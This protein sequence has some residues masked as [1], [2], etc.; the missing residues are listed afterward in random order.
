MSRRFLIETVTLTKKYY[1]LEAD[2]L[3]AAQDEVT[4]KRMMSY[5]QC[6]FD[7]VIVSG[8]EIAHDDRIPYADPIKEGK[9]SAKIDLENLTNS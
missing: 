4:M 9:Y 1:V 5:D 7:E 6:K 8:F 2:D 3:I